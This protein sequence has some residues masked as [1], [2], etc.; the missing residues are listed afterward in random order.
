TIIAATGDHYMR[1][2]ENRFPLDLF[3]DK[4]VPFFIHIPSTIKANLAIDFN[5]YRLG[6][7]KDIMPTLFALSL[8]DCEYWHLAGRNLLSN[9]AE[10]KFN[11]A[12]NE[13]VFI[14]P[15]AVYDL[16]SENIV[17]YQWNKQNG[18]TE[19]QLE[20]GEEEAKEIR[21][22]SDLLYWQIN[23]QVEGIK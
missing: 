18:E 5:P 8:S 17:K 2:M 16:H 4:T 12:F 7:H 15:D 23:Y 1:A 13:T 21:S 14:T 19:K 20:I 3:L 10:N 9:Q 6:S 11:F 22:Y